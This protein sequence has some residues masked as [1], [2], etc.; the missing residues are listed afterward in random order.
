MLL[1]IEPSTHASRASVLVLLIH[2]SAPFRSPSVDDLKEGKGAEYVDAS[3]LCLIFISDGYV[4]S[5]NCMRELLRAVFVKKPILALTEPEVRKGGLTRE[6]VQARLEAA[7]SKYERWGLA[8]EMQDW[9]FV[10]LPTAAL[11]LDAL[12]VDALYAPPLEWARIG[13]FQDVTL[14]LIA[15]AVLPE[16][17]QTYVQGELVS[18]KLRPLRPP[19]GRHH[20]YYDPSLNPGAAELLRELAQTR[21]FRLV[22]DDA[23]QEASVLTELSSLGRASFFSFTRSLEFLEQPSLHISTQGAELASC[24]HF[25]VYLTAQTWTGGERSAAFAAEVKR[26][27]DENVHLLLCHEMPGPG[28]QAERHGCSFDTFFQNDEGATP[29]ELLQRGIYSQIAIGLKGGE[30]RKASMALLNDVLASGSNGYLAEMSKA[31]ADQSIEMAMLNAMQGMGAMGRRLGDGV[32]KRASGLQGITAAIATP[33]VQ[34]S[35]SSCGSVATDVERD[36]GRVLGTFGLP[37]TMRKRS[38]ETTT[39]A[40]SVSVVS[41]AEPTLAGDGAEIST[42]M[43]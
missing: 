4:S 7:D 5:P 41:A 35:M 30:W 17:G 24:D 25:L 32:I 33:S 9:G 31:D 10:P 34:S 36:A 29:H 15:N 13:I 40:I 23:K 22:E 38:G 37:S 11:L 14:R 42:V 43:Q 2:P 26:A 16:Q 8:K 21:G 12:Y 19:L 18:R 1:R 27:M 39:T 3:Q 20:V 28:G 6:Q